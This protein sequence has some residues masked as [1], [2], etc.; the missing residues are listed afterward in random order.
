MTHPASNPH[1]IRLAALAAILLGVTMLT[2]V[3]ASAHQEPAPAQAVVPKDHSEFPEGPGR[4]TTLR[5]CSKCHSPNN[6]LAMG[7]DR[8]GWT[9]LIS[10]MVDLGAQ[11]SDEDFTAIADYLTA[12]FPPAAAAPAAAK[13]N[14]NKASASQLATALTLTTQEADQLV[15]YR[16]KNGDFKTLDD[17]KKVPAIDPKK[18]DAAKDAI[19]F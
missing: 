16:E 12:S 17:L 10:K 19:A 2:G 3:A 6:I 1:P 9:E 4:D 15:A 11:G 13:V 5:V 18:F 7:R 8:K 14:V